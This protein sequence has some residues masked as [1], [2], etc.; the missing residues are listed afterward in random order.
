MST[1]G[2]YVEGKD[3][4]FCVQDLDILEIYIL[5]MRASS[6]AVSRGEEGVL[7]TL[8]ERGPA[9]EVGHASD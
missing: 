7:R 5:G 9:T 3:A 1:T 6:L 4:L 2:R 8:F